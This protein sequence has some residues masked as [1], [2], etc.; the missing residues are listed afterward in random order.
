MGARPVDEVK[1]LLASLSNALNVDDLDEAEAL[2][3]RLDAEI[4]RVSPSQKAQMDQVRDDYR[5]LCLIIADRRDTVAGE[6]SAISRSRKAVGAY[7]D[8]L[9]NKPKKLDR[10]A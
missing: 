7:R 5:K 2:I 9:P 10:Q 6:L 8:A 3:A 1:R 4:L